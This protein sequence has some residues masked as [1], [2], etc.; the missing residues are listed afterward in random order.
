MKLC[1]VEHFWTYLSSPM[2]VIA[3]YNSR[4]EFHFSEVY[5]FQNWYF[6]GIPENSA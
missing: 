4:T 5:F 1:R 3:E 2:G 6:S